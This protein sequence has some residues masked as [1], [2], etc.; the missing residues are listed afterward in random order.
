VLI[1]SFPT[2]DA[3]AEAAATVPAAVIVEVGDATWQDTWRQHAEPIDIGAQ[4]RVAPAWKDV[5]LGDG[6]VVLRIEPGPC[7]GGG[8]HPT[9][10]MLLAEIERRAGRGTS[11]LDVGTGSGVLAVAAAVFGARPVVGVDIDPAAIPVSRAN[12]EANGVEVDVSTTPVGDVNGRFDLVLA[13]L[14]AGTLVS[15]ASDLIA[16]IAPAGTLLL[17][18]LLPGQWRHVEPSF[19]SLDTDA[20]IELDGWLSAV[21][22]RK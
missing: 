22:S 12:A 16:R 20:V 14:S 13:N 11:V 5:P 17:S 9:T 4:L 19:G 3:L 6:R 2:D 15:L 10:R 1:A 7:F 8:N 21:L 18:G